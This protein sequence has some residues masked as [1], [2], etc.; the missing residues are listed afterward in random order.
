[1]RSLGWHVTLFDTHLQRLLWIYGGADRLAGKASVEDLV[2]QRAH[3]QGRLTC[4]DRL[5]ERHQEKCT[6]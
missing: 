4:I 6:C 1:M 2:K 5:E 3:S